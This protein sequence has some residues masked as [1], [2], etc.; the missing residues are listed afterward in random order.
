MNICRGGTSGENLKVS[1]LSWVV[2][3]H[4][5]QRR[6]KN[7][8]TNKVRDSKL[9]ST[10][11]FQQQSLPMCW[12]PGGYAVWHE[13]PAG[14][15]VSQRRVSARPRAGRLFCRNWQKGS[16]RTN[17]GSGRAGGYV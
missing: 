3:S 2:R 7:K 1:Q 4:R 17:R 15:R 9:L 11:Q 14:Q 10:A 6:A 16:L 13:Q 8:S 12:L 5:P